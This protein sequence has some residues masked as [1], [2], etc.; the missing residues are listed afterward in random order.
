[1]EEEESSRV[2]SPLHG[3][4]GVVADGRAVVGVRSA[5]EG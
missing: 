2:C 3:R 4:V 5:D 1:M